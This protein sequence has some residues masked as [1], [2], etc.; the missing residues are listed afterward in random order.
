MD[1][2]SYL[3]YS[4]ALILAL[5]GV[6]MLIADWLRDE[7]GPNFNFMLLGMV[8]LILVGGVVLSLMK[9]KSDEKALK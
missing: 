4:L 5:V 6:K 7:L 3:K 2:F 8:A 1:K 9:A